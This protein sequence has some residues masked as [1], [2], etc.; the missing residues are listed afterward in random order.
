MLDNG[1]ETH[2]RGEVDWAERKREI[3]RSTENLS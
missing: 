1:N 2:E 3:G